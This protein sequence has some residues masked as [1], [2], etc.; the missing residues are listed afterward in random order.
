[1]NS[2]VNAVLVVI[3]AAS[4]C[5]PPLL[6]GPHAF[7]QPAAAIRAC[8]LVSKE[9]V[10]KHLPWAAVLDNM[11]IEEEPIG[12]SGSS[13]NYP[14]VHIQVLPFSQRTIDMARQ[15]GGLETVSGV[16]DEAYF[17]NNAGRY[18]ELYVKSGK[19]LVTLQANLDDNMASVK[20][21][22]VALARALVAKVR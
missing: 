6:A 15:K 19:H 5:P 12:T 2:L 9:E 3:G 11:P 14:S 16:G 7:E 22:V 4:V 10:K 21:G 17:Y 13:C 20:P 1:V 18:A 8:S